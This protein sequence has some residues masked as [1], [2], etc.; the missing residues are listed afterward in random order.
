MWLFFFFKDF[1]YLF[2]HDRQR[3]TEREAETQAEGEAVSMQGAD[4][5]LSI[6]SLQAVSYTH[7]RAHETRV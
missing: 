2:I 7:L 4:V 5:G 1:I 6:L 3:D